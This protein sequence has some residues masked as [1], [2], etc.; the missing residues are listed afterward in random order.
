MRRGRLEKKKKGGAFFLYWDSKSI[1]LILVFLNDV[2]LVW[3]LKCGNVQGLRDIPS[4]AGMEEE[5]TGTGM[6][7][8]VQYFA[9]IYISF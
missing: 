6:I 8:Y 7:F 5:K 4:L 2:I 3:K 1:L 9:H